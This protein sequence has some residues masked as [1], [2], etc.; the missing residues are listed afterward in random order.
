[1]C[2]GFSDARRA[3]AAAARR[4]GR[5]G[6]RR[7]LHLA[8]LQ[9]LSARPTPFWASSTSR[10]EIL[11]LAFHVDYWNY[12]GWN[13]PYAKPMA[14]SASA[15][16]RAT[17]LTST[18]R[19]WWWRER[20]KAS[21][22]SATPSRPH[23]RRRRQ[24]AA[25]PS[26]ALRWRKDGALARRCRRAAHRRPSSRRRIWLV[27]FDAAHTTKVLRGENEGTTATDYQA[28][29]SYKRLGAW[30]GWALELVGAGGPDAKGLGDGG[31]RRVAASRRHRPHP[32]RRAHRAALK[33]LAQAL[34][35][36]STDAARRPPGR[37]TPRPR[38]CAPDRAAARQN[39]SSASAAPSL[40]ARSPAGR[41]AC[42]W[43]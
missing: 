37:A 16:I 20:R 15:A 1:M 32:R 4:R 12:I 6:R 10:P 14:A 28:V 7:A 27:G 29:R 18:R 30:P 41:S 17:A 24:D 19:R 11:A 3:R 42:A 22:P 34:A 8:R 43:G 36:P 33:R 21:A 31:D 40:P 26:L 35:R 38:G 39:R 23:P 9:F 13:D 25:A 2:R 5:A